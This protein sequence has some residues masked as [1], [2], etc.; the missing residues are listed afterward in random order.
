MQEGNGVKRG[1]E[2]LERR[3]EKEQEEKEVCVTK[4]EA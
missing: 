1:A 4:R 2:G 3:K